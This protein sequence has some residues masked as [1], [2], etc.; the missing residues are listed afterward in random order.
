MEIKVKRSSRKSV[1]IKITEKGEVW[2]LC[3]YKFAIKEIN[4]I[5]ESKKKWIESTIYKV[6]QKLDSKKSFYEYKKIMFLGEE[7]DIEIT[8]NHINFGEYSLKYRKGTSVKN[9][10]K[11]FLIK[12]ANA[13]ILNRLDAVSDAIKINYNTS[14]IVSARKKWGSCDNLKNIALNY[15]LIMLPEPYIDYV[16]VHELCHI[17]HMNHSKQ[18]WDEVEKYCPN[19]K[20]LKKNISAFSFVLELF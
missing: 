13:F 11:Q 18:F 3:P 6:Q 1:A 15:R 20:I 5:V 10:I 14:K 8:S 19:H 16:C 17:K 2:V 12:Q 4:Q 7:Y 9:C